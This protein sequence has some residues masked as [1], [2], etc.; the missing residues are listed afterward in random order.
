M[1]TAAEAYE[2][3]GK[4]E[5]TTEMIENLL[6]EGVDWKVINRATGIDQNSFQNLK[7][8]WQRDN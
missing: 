6:K 7:D 1:I 5:T 4:M 2:M 8:K 3:K